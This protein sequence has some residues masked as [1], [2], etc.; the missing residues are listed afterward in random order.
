M[1]SRRGRK[2]RRKKLSKIEEIRQRY[3]KENGEAKAISKKKKAASKME[4]AIEKF[5]DE[6]RKE[7]KE[8]HQRRD[9]GKDIVEKGFFGEESRKKKNKRNSEYIFGITLCFIKDNSYEIGSVDK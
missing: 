9:Q 4:I 2:T 7:R 8:Q 3:K 6:A 1:A 5:V